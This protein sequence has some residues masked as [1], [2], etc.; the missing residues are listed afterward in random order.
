[1]T[2]YPQIAGVVFSSTRYSSRVIV[3]TKA[4]QR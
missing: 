1:M 4:V 3:V 2:N